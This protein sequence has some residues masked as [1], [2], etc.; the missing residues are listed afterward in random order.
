MAH[1]YLITNIINSKI[2]I[3]QT[4]GKRKDYFAGG[5]LIKQAIR[6]YGKENFSRKILIEGDF[7]KIKLDELERY[8]IKEYKSSDSKIGYN[9]AP[10]GEGH[11]GYKYSKETI[12][13]RKI[14]LKK[15]AE[16]R[17]YWKTPEQIE[18]SASKN[19][20]RKFGEEFRQKCRERALSQEI[21]EDRRNKMNEGVRKHYYKE[22]D[23]FTLDNRYIQTF[24]IIMDAVRELK[25]PAHAKTGIINNLKKRQNSCQSYI[26][27]YKEVAIG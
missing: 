16:A 23:V 12:E 6:K 1:I 20:G 5:K 19:R 13:K 17:G 27:K 24:G 10:G 8:Y 26:F 2:Y 4:N 7:D 22:F 14:S 9:L 15:S 25:L 18:N 11:I 3:G 21:T